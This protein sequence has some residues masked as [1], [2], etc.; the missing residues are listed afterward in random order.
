M[1]VLDIGSLKGSLD[2]FHMNEEEINSLSLNKTEN[3]LASADDSGAINILNLAKKKR[4]K[5]I[6]EK[7]L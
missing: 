5:Q 2:H 7:T 3:L 6:L 1:S 4:R